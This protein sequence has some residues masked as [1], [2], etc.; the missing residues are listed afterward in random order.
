MLEKKATTG[1]AVAL[2]IRGIIANL[3]DLETV[4]VFKSI[5]LSTRC[6]LSN[7]ACVDRVARVASFLVNITC[8]F[9]IYF[10]CK[11]VAATA[12]NISFNDVDFFFFTHVH[13]S[14]ADRAI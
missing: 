8:G 6:R 4:L 11:L 1:F 7:H 9:G 14:D 2:K 3:I 5:N 10:N 12:A 13:S